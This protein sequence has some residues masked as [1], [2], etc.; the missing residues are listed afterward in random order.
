VIKEIIAYSGHEPDDVSPVLSRGRRRREVVRD[1]LEHFDLWVPRLIAEAG[2]HA[3]GRFLE[4]FAATIR[5]K[6]RRLAYL[7][8]VGQFFAWCDQRRVSELADIEPLHIAAYIEALQAAMSKPTV[9]QHLA[10][11]GMLFDWLVTGHVVM[12]NQGRLSYVSRNRP[13][14]VSG[15]WRNT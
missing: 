10:A 1:A 6:N 3:A 9:K 11:I 4:F 5:N 12:V 2:D 8:A 15:S 14:C 13:H 7:H